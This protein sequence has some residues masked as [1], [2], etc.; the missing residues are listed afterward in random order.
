[1]L[2]LELNKQTRASNGETLRSIVEDD[3]HKH[4]DHRVVARVTSS[5][6]GK[7]ASVADFT[8]RHFVIYSV[9]CS[10]S[11]TICLD[12]KNPNFV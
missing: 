4:S 8:S 10:S 11:P 5:G 6:S 3:F 9:C 12:L 1:M 7:T 2:R